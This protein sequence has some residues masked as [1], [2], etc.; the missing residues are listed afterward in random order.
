MHRKCIVITEEIINIRG[1]LEMNLRIYDDNMQFTK[2][3]R[4]VLFLI[5]FH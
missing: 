3:E 5:V 4:W 1:L 2:I